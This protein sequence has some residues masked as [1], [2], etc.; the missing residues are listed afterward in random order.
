MPSYVYKCPE[1]HQWTVSH[2]ISEDPEIYCDIDDKLGHRVPQSVP[3]NFN[4]KG[5]Y[6]TDD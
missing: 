1:G 2:S 3:T 6:S 5:F 4:A